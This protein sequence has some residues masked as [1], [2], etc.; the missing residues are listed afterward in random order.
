[1]TNP[2][3]VFDDG[4]S[5]ILGDKSDESLSS[6]WDDDVDGVLETQ[7]FVNGLSV[8]HGYHLNGIDGDFRFLECSLEDMADGPVGMKGLRA[9]S[10]NHGVSRFQTEPGLSLIHI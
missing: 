6:P 8:G 3:V 4:D 10:Q 9:A 7:H 5:G 1:M 2:L